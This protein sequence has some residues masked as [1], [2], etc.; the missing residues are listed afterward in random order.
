MVTPRD[1]GMRFDL[2]GFRGLVSQ[3]EMATSSKTRFTESEE[4]M[5]CYIIELSVYCQENIE[6]MQEQLR[7]TMDEPFCKQINMEEEINKFYLVLKNAIEQ[8]VLNLMSFV[9]EGFSNITK[10][11][12][13]VQTEV[14]DQSEYVTNII[15]HL[16]DAL[17]YLS[18]L[19]SSVN[20]KFL[21]D[22][23]VI[24]MLQSFTSNI[25]KCER[26]NEQGAQQLLLDL[27]SLSNFLKNIINIG[28]SERFDED[29]MQIFVKKLQAKTSR[30][31]S[32]L[33]VLLSP[34]EAIVDTYRS[35]VPDNNQN[36]L[37]AIMDLKGISK[38]EKGT[39]IES[40]N[41][42][43]STGFGALLMSK[44]ALPDVNLPHINTSDV[45]KGVRGAF[46]FNN[47]NS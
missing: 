19:I 7:T 45:M 46:S 14:I 40:F 34:T 37:Q 47:T 41:Q 15:Q 35:L 36:E 13:G 30:L 1:S 10:L 43:K 3:N 12:L 29:E 9:E 4:K 16:S 42:P 20:F 22:H 28:D 17:H 27:T 32:I 39:I 2:L 24:A 8:L 26:I 25:F 38:S 44:V 18:D 23:L 5:A 31:E 33:K 21:C 6:I 11:P